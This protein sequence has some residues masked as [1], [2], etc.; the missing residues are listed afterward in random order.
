MCLTTLWAIE[1]WVGGLEYRPWWW[2][3]K[4]IINSVFKWGV[5][6]GFCKIAVSLMRGLFIDTV[7]EKAPDILTLEEIKKFLIAAKLLNHRWYSTLSFAVLTGMRSGELYSLTWDQIDLEKN[8]I[9]VDRSY[10]EGPSY[11]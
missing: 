8:L 1:N 7:E 9:L 4:N 11:D 5:E 3:V 10:C 2:K 6:F